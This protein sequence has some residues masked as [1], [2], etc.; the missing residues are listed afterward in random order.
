MGNIIQR[1]GA[2]LHEL[3]LLVQVDPELLRLV[4]CLGALRCL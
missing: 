2:V 3:R 4:R 1:I